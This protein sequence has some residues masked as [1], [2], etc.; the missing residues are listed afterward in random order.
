MTGKRRMQQMRTPVHLKNQKPE[1]DESEPLSM[2][3]ETDLPP[4]AGVK[5]A[6]SSNYQR[7][8]GMA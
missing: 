3:R 8:I 6:I 7:A 1:L 2:L 4:I 5:C